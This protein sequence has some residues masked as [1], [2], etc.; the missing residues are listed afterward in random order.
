MDCLV[1]HEPITGV[2]YNTVNVHIC[3]R[4]ASTYTFSQLY[5][6]L[7]DTMAN[8]PFTRSI[9]APVEVVGHSVMASHTTADVDVADV[10]STMY[11]DACYMLKKDYMDKYRDHPDARTLW[12]KAHAEIPVEAGNTASHTGLEIVTE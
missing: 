9:E 10:P 3:G 7:H 8:C 1:C 5:V 2:A 6:I 11:A 4:C 12:Y